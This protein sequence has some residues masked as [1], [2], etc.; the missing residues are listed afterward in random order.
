MK[1]TVNSLILLTSILSSYAIS[2][3]VEVDVIEPKLQTA[4]TL[5]HLTGSIEAKQNSALTPLQ[6]G[7]IAELYVEQGDMVLKGQKLLAL[8]DKLARLE[9]DQLLSELSASQLNV[10]EKQRLYDE[11]LSLKEESL[12]AETSIQQRR[13]ELVIA[14][15]QKA[16]IQSKV[17]RQQEIVARHKLYAPFSG[18]VSRRNVDLGEWVTQQ[19]PVF[20]LVE[21]QSLR[22]KVAI[23]QEYYSQLVDKINIPVTVIPDAAVNLS[24][25][26]KL[27]RLVQAADP[28]SRTFTGLIDLNDARGLASGMSAQAQLVIPEQQQ[29]VIWLPKKALKVHPDGGHSVFYFENGQAH[30]ML[31]KVHEYKLD[32]IGVVGADANKLYIASGVELLK[33]KQLVD[34]KGD[35]L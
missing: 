30:R 6:S 4:E 32:S 29:Q 3:N 33:D 13:S 1:F 34:V 17:N 18:V 25:Q 23:P 24:K 12:I 26:V 5:L 20:S 15:A 21:G 10:E 9:L 16:Q 27:T 2:K 31:V 11:T 8:D 22:L 28:I 7:L 19:T 35:K 14:K